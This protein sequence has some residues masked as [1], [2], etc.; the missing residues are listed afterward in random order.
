MKKILV[1]D[2]EQD[3][4]KLLSLH[5]SKKGYNVICANGGREGLE[6][7]RAHRPDLITLDVMMPDIN[8]VA[9]LEEIKSDPVLKKIPVIMLSAHFSYS[10]LPE[11]KHNIENF[12]EKPIDFE[13]LSRTIEKALPGGKKENPTALIIDDEKAMAAVTGSYLKKC[14]IKFITAYSGKEGVDKA[15]EMHPDLIVLDLVMPGMNGFEVLEELKKNPETASIPTIILTSSI[16]DRYRDRSY[17]LGAAAYL[18]KSFPE[19]KLIKEIEKHIEERE[20][21]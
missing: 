6:K 1:I 4:T 11:L 3:V 7:A 13:K 8:G 2:D 9:V 12:I 19:E 18:D 20:V 10:S 17:R 16:S 15:F 5:L 21:S 14:G